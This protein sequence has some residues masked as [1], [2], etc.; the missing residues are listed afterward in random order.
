MRAVRVLASHAV[1]GFGVTFL[2]VDYM[3][4]V[5]VLAYRNENVK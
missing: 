5:G 1:Q 3:V 2:T 4:H